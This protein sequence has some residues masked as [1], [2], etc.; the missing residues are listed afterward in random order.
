M[1]RPGLLEWAVQQLAGSA[2]GREPGAERSPVQQCPKAQT[3]GRLL[4][5]PLVRRPAR[6][7]C[8]PP[9]RHRFLA[10]SVRQRSRAGFRPRPL[11]RHHPAARPAPCR[12]PFRSREPADRCPHRGAARHGQQ[13][14]L[15]A[16]RATCPP[17]RRPTRSSHRQG[18]R[19]GSPD[20]GDGPGRER[21]TET[22][23]SRRACDPSANGFATQAARVGP[24]LL[25]AL[26]P[27]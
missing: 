18:A 8:R 14:D 1:R 20:E 9:R 25:A 10:W 15:R 11:V 21:W 3:L 16:A 6:Q 12:S 7:P 2:P 27:W 19:A 5:R 26:S 23:D 13:A 4:S 24:A 22:R 17:G